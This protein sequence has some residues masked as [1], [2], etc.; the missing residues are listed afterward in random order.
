MG[1]RWV[2]GDIHGCIQTFRSLVE[3]KIQP[4]KTDTLFLLGDYIDR[5]P[6]SK[7]VLDYIFRLREKN[8]FHVISLMGNHEYMLIHA[9]ENEDFFKL[10]LLNS[11]QTTLSDFDLLDGNPP[12]STTLQK[13]PGIYMEFLLQLSYYAET[14]GFFLTH[15]C[16]TGNATNPLED[17]GSM[18][19]GRIEAY[20][21]DFLDGKILVH[22]HTPASLEDI[23]NRIEDPL[24]KVINLDGGCVYKNNAQLGNL[25]ALELNTLSLT[26][27]KNRD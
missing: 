23:R 18:I 5:G 13:I 24:G 8:L 19:W 4:Q 15:G 3:N 25:V 16:F 6:D 20:P 21:E 22:G 12:E 26:W 11:G 2:I 27:V 10:W 7:A 14:P 17:I 1:K 9:R